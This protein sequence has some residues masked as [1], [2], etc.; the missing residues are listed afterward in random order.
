MFIGSAQAAS[1]RA[2]VEVGSILEY[3]GFM[4]NWQGY[5]DNIAISWD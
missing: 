5:I 4:S 2:L 3:L 1:G